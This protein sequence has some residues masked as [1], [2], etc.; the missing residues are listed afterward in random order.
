[1]RSI[2]D[3]TSITIVLCG[4]AI[5]LVAMYNWFRF[6]ELW[7]AEMLARTPQASESSIAFAWL[8]APFLDNVSAECNALRR[9]ANR[10]VAVFLA[11]WALGF[12]FM[13][14]M[15]SIGVYPAKP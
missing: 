10:S 2:A 7:R 3:A 11:L 13:Y 1:V 9:R 8:Y 4:F 15:H 14:A 5:G 6:H 12:I